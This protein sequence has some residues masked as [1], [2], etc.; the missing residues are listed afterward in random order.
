MLLAPLLLAL[1]S[2]ANGAGPATTLA[3]TAAVIRA[4][5]DDDRRERSLARLNA[6]R[7]AAG[8]APVTRSDPLTQSASRHAAYLSEHGFHSAPGFHAENPALSDFTGADPFV[9]M[10]A[11]G[12]DMAYATEVIGDIGSA[13]TDSDCVDGLMHTI[14]HAALLLG[15]VTEAGFGYGTGAAA[16]SCTID[17]GTPLAASPARVSQAGGLV[18]YPWPGMVISSGSFRPESENPRPLFE[19]LP[20]SPTGAPVMVGL[21]DAAMAGQDRPAAVRIQQFELRDMAGATVPSVVLADAAITGPGVVADAA[22][23]G[24]FVALVPRR[25]LAPGRYR[26]ILRASLDS[27]Q[28][29]QPAPW[30]FSVAAP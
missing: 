14:Y 22:L 7:R 20:D 16:G 2:G 5:Q 30:L 11:A 13:S 24:L 1:A 27:G 19:F 10:R 29:L 9:R 8:V 15:R 25:P 21:R 4:S 3:D 17:L 28:T 23:R 26:V 6:L 12:Y 18:R